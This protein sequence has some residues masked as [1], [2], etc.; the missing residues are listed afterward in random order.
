M[1]TPFGVLFSFP[2]WYYC[3]YRSW[4][5]FSLGGCFP[6][7][8]PSHCQS[9]VLCL[10]HNLVFEQSTGL[11]P[12]TVCLSSQLRLRIEIRV[13][14]AK[15]NPTSPL[16]FW[17]AIRFGLSRVGSPLL[18]GSQLILFSLLLLRC[19]RSQ[20]FAFPKRNKRCLEGIPLTIDS[21]SGI[22][23][24]K[25]CLRF[26]G[27][28]RSSPRPSSPYQAKPSTIQRLRV[29]WLTS[30]TNACANPCMAIITGRP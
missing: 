20:R 14:Y 17:S 21:H 30:P 13:A 19:F 18:T 15:A 10:S 16:P 28:Y 9:Q 25:G 6:P 3:A 24:I 23:R 29:G 1:H 2:L 26:P 4:F 11:S 5:V 8:S 12:F 22:S 27:A 7:S